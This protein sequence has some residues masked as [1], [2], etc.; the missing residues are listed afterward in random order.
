MQ[1][2]R[3]SGKVLDEAPI[4]HS[5]SQECSNFCS[6]TWG[7]ELDYS[8]YLFWICAKSFFINNKAK[9]GHTVGS[10][11]AFFWFEVETILAQPFQDFFEYLQ[12]LF[13]GTCVD[14]SI[15]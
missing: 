5:N 9:K 1:R 13:K 12:V 11:G 8:F 14:D 2:F 10:D 3:D 7:W 4:I 15:I 6:V